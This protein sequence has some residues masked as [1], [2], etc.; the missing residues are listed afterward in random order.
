MNTFQESRT[1]L[2]N[3]ASGFLP[4]PRAASDRDAIGLCYEF[5]EHY[6]ALKAENKEQANT[7]DEFNRLLTKL[8]T[9]NERLRQAIRESSINCP[10]CGRHDF[11]LMAPAFEQA[12]DVAETFDKGGLPI[13]A[14][15]TMRKN[16]DELIGE[17]E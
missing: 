13:V 12:C 5:V 4:G 8:R 14:I 2:M 17:Q 3:L 11:G 16:R 9:E 10:S 15:Q 6:T 7:I 1:R